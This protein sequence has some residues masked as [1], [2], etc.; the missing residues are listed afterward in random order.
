MQL[1]TENPLN[2][3]VAVSAVLNGKIL[4]QKHGCGTFWVPVSCQEP[5]E[6]S[7]P[8]VELVL[9]HY[10]LDRSYGWAIHRSAL[11]WALHPSGHRRGARPD[12]SRL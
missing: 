9:D 10:R 2:L 12:R 11:P 5:D 6:A 3:D 4:R 8:E 1:E 7:S